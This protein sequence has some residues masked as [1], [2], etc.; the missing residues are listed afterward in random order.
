MDSRHLQSFVSVVELG[1]IAEAA[2]HLDLPPATV[3]QRLRALERDIGSTLVVRAGRTVKPTIAGQRILDRARAVLAELRDLRSAA[4]D[5]ELPAG[6]LH[7]GCIRSALAGM[8]PPIIKNWIARHP[9]IKLE[10]DPA[11]TTALYEQVLAGKVDAAVL[12]HPLFALPKSCAWHALRREALILLAPATMEVEDPLAAIAREPLVR[13]DR[14][15]VAG[16]LADD[17]LTRHAIRPKVSLEL[18][19]LD[20]IARFVAEGLGVSVLP[21]WAT[22]EP[23][24]S[25]LRKWPLPPPVPAR[26]IG[27]LWQRNTVRAPL[28]EAFV[29]LAAARF[30]APPSDG[31]P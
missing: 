25:S 22:L 14:R 4:S 16:K 12:V 2:R 9:H 6:P 27:V 17:Y 13:Y 26:T 29:A 10:I 7:L 18:D 21:D 8:L 31:L 11:Q 5:T 1:S 30:S 28:V 23:L 24:S 3:A 15:V 20:D 19:G